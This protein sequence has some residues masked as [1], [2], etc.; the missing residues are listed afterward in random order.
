M[1]DT[2]CLESELIWASRSTY[3]SLCGIFFYSFSIFQD[4]QLTAGRLYRDLN[5]LLRTLEDAH[6]S[7]SGYGNQTDQ[8]FYD[9]VKVG[10]NW[11]LPLTRE[12]FHA[13]TRVQ[14]YGKYVGFPFLKATPKNWHF[15]LQFDHF[16]IAKRI[17]FP[18]PWFLHAGFV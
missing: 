15:P 8:D 11:Y 12:Q 16:R 2:V 6:A 9:E 7:G 10:G 14:N 1:L 17:C 3:Q 4:E 18:K 13:K 5:R